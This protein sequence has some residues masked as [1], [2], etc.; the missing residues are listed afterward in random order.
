MR[1]EAELRRRRGELIAM[2]RDE[3]A[4]LREFERTGAEADV[5]ASVLEH[6][7]YLDRRI[8]ALD[9]RSSKATNEASGARPD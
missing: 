4:N 9:A 2:R 6:I 8:E 3:E 7:A 1:E 5:I